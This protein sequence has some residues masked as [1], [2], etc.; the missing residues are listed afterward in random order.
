MYS[1]FNFPLESD[2]KHDL[3]DSFPVLFVPGNAGSYQQIRSLASTCIRRQIQLIEALKFVFYTID[4]G[5][6][7][8]GLSG[9]LIE[10]QTRFVH[11]SLEQIKR[12]HPSH[13]NG[14]ILL[15]H[16]VG[17]FISKSLFALPDFDHNSIPILI[18][19][20]GPLVK[21]YLTFDSKMHELY[22]N[23]NN[24]WKKHSSSM[25]NTLSIS[26]SG[27]HSDRLVPTHLSMDPQF[28][29]SLT[30]DA[31]ADVWLSTDHVSILWCR[32]L[33][34]KLAHLLSTL[35][36]KKEARLVAEK[37]VASLLA[38]SELMSRPPPGSTTNLTSKVWSTSRS[39]RVFKPGHLEQI[40][41][42]DLTNLIHVLN[43]TDYSST[44]FLI[45]IEHLAPFKT[46]GIFGCK[47]LSIT[48][49]QSTCSARSQLMDFSH[50]IPSLSNH[51]KKTILKFDSSQLPMTSYIVLDLSLDSGSKTGNSLPE[52][53]TVF[54]DYSEA[55]ESFR[56]PSLIEFL[57][58]KMSLDNQQTLEISSRYQG[59][60]S[61]VK[62]IIDN[63]NY[64][65][66][67]FTLRMT[68]EL[69]QS[70]VAYKHRV[71]TVLL[72]EGKNLV[73]GFL[74]N[75]VSFDGLIS[76]D[77]KLSRSPMIHLINETK[78]HH[79]EFYFDGSCKNS[80]VLELDLFGLLLFIINT[81]LVRILI[82]ASYL[83]KMT[84]AL[85]ARSLR[86]PTEGSVIYSAMG[87]IFIYYSSRYLN[88]QALL[89][90][91]SGSLHDEILIISLVGFLSYG[92]MALLAFVM[93]RLIDVG[94]IVFR[95]ISI[96]QLENH[97]LS[98]DDTS[99]GNGSPKPAASRA[100]F[101]DLVWPLIVLVAI[102]SHFF[103]AALASTI[104]LI[105]LIRLDVV[106]NAR[107]TIQQ[108]YN[109]SSNRGYIY[110][111]KKLARI[112]SLISS[113]GTV[114]LLSLIANIPSAM[115]KIKGVSKIDGIFEDI[116]AIETLTSFTS[117]I[118]SLI[119]IKSICNYLEHFSLDQKSKITTLSLPLINSLPLVLIGAAGLIPV[120]SIESNLRHMNNVLLASLIYINSLIARSGNQK[121]Q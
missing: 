24:H 120:V 18:S 86:Q 12:M 53:L 3:K 13:L 94:V 34:F 114:C 98:S 19:L 97:T 91:R 117:T 10:D 81:N 41:K 7:L 69:C 59:S 110:D 70:K 66:Q 51:P 56:V 67:F 71:P 119:L 87:L 1:E 76:V 75:A 73:G 50:T 28:D 101:N 107:K 121:T 84:V 14:I 106:M 109:S 61:Y 113:L 45:L 47:G 58:K 35:M 116:M 96:R 26:I 65:T 83:I 72:F 79:L 105:Q 74:P 102:F 93:R 4:F 68:S 27:G 9:D 22:E 49:G 118:L 25:R 108:N 60:Y 21:P 78:S 2:I 111:E 95:V 104:N 54:R 37:R 57:L 17:G 43:I 100:E 6:Q 52:A 82:C 115:V 112:K 90:S 92:A 31:I 8:S 20:A 29:L 36:D 33:V 63:L 77:I 62:V 80:F 48:N 39:L 103:S 46:S 5:G 40:S 11:Q 23:T 64:D 32:E 89:S 44:D 16:S 55:I 30:S 38:E 99:N 15:G 85:D 42:S 88:G